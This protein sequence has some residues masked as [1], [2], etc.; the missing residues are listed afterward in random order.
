M[1]DGRFKS[2]SIGKHLTAG[3][4]NTIY[5]C[6]KGYTAHITLLFVANLGVGNQTVTIQWYNSHVPDTFYILGGYPI[7]GYSYLKL[8]GSYLTL[9]TDDSLIIM[10]QA[11]STMD[12]TITV[13]EHYDPYSRQ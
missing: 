12:A 4:E 10:P 6:P 11:G 8:D 13:E 3:V 1:F 5:T 7:S 2:R 9:N